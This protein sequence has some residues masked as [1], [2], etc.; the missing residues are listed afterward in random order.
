MCETWIDFPAPGLGL[1]TSWLMQA[2]G[3]GASEWDHCLSKTFFL[4]NHGN[5]TV[6]LHARISLEG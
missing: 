4:E 5:K 6:K 1:V 2:S 3:D